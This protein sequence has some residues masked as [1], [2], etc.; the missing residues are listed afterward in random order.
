MTQQNT[1]KKQDRARI[2]INGKMISFY[3]PP[4]ENFID[5]G[6]SIEECP[7]T[8]F[9][10][11]CKF[12]TGESVSSLFASVIYVPPEFELLLDYYS[13]VWLAKAYPTLNK[14]QHQAYRLSFRLKF[15]P[16]Y[17]E[18]LQ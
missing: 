1:D 10:E 14:I 8:K 17:T 13:G 3:L 15:G 16:N 18:Y 11:Y 7:Y 4:I 2:K 6:P 9:Y 5:K 12:I